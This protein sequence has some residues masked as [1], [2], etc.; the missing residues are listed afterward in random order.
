VIPIA[1]KSDPM[2]AS[3]RSLGTAL[4]C[5]CQ[6]GSDLVSCSDVLAG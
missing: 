6:W 4:T 2:M 5:V 3:A 1:T